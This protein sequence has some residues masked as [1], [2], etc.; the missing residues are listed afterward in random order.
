MIHPCFFGDKNNV[1]YFTLKK[2]AEY[3][4]SPIKSEDIKQA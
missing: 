1:I 4:Y 3:Q 2:K